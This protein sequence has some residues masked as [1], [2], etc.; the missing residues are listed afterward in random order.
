MSFKLSQALLLISVIIL[1]STTIFMKP[2]VMATNSTT[3]SV[4]NPQTGRVNFF[5]YTNVTSVG[6]KFNATVWVYNATDLYAYQVYLMYNTTLLNA[7]NAWRP[8]NDPQWVFDGRTTVF[9]NVDPEEGVKVG[10][11][12]V[13]V[14]DVIL[15][16]ES[17][18]NGTGILAIVEFEILLAPLELRTLECNLAIDNSDTYVLN[19]D[20]GEIPVIKENGHYSFSWLEPGLEVKPHEHVAVMELEEF[21]ISVWL[22]N[23]T[24]SDRLVGL[25]FN[26]HYNITLLNITQI[27][28]GSFLTQFGST[29][30]SNDV[31]ANF[32]NVNVTLTPTGEYP[33]GSGIIAF[34]TFQGT[35]QDQRQYQS[36]LDLSNILFIDNNSNPIQPTTPPINGS[37]TVLPDGSSF[38]TIQANPSSIVIGS[39]VTISGLVSA[40]ETKTNVDVTIHKRLVGQAWV[41]L[42]TL[43]TNSSGH[44]SYI[45]KPTELGTFELKANWTGDAVNDP[46]ESSITTLT[47]KKIASAITISLNP[48]T[49]TVEENLTIKGAINVTRPDVNVTI[50]YRL[51][52]GIWNTLSTVQTDNASQYAFIWIT[53]KG[54]T[55]EIYSSWQGDNITLGA[56]SQKA[57]LTV[58]KLPSSITIEVI[59][60]NTTVTDGTSINISGRITADKPK[61]GVNVAIYQYQLY[62]NGSIPRVIATAT[63]DTNGNYTY[64][65]AAAKY[66]ARAENETFT[67]YAYFAGDE[68]TSES[69]SSSALWLTVLKNN[70]TITL[71]INPADVTVKAGSIITISGAITPTKAN[72][73]VSIYCRIA[74][75]PWKILTA[76]D[77]DSGSVYIYSWTTTKKTFDSLDT[78]ELKAIWSGD[79]ATKTA[80]SNISMITVEKVPSTLTIAI[81]ASIIAIGSNVT[82]SGTVTP[83]RTN[84][85]I[86]IYYREEGK[87]E[88]LPLFAKTDNESRYTYLWKPLENA[89]FELYASWEGDE[90]TFAN[91]S[92]AIILKVNLAKSWIT[93]ETNSEA[94]VA[95][96]NVTISGTITPKKAIS[97]VVIYYRT[98]SENISWTVLN[99][100][101]TDLNGNYEYIWTTTEPGIFEL[102]ARWQGDNLTEP[103]K[104][105]I[106]IVKVETPFNVMTYAPYIIGGIAIIAITFSVIWYL[107]T[108]KKSPPTTAG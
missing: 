49:I 88:E 73:K 59:P 9:G 104:S 66:D 72:V 78:F 46:A 24:S 68:I 21:N 2:H 15:G 38:I 55:Y 97:E 13:Q 44:Y 61:I 62:V 22:N 16:T 86:T 76:V 51:S 29:V 8:I 108:K 37:Y 75:E 6:H 80:E 12:F 28:E 32:A 102:E 74:G 7:T 96:S 87:T 3:M 101:M 107:K 71:N 39:D 50:Y 1:S 105:E 14:G 33:E 81:D 53:T 36:S 41:T 64:F 42:T 95:G 18:F 20:L 79:A 103:A 98:K 100:T 35:Y 45:W 106:K 5:F 83:T 70:S 65:W 40:N 43:Q 82:I 26:L 99:S 67:F 77:T 58:K 85:D 31:D 69:Y 56:E 4:I 25:E 10:F 23:I 57:V 30:F 54:G 84:A 90:N 89:T 63:I 19:S 92:N 91:E 27:T 11:D 52:G 48:P 93:I 17:T 34:I 60:Y 47:V 94:T